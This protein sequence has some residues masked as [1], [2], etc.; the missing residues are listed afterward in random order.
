MYGSIIQLRNRSNIL[1][2]SIFNRIFRRFRYLVHKFSRCFRWRWFIWFIRFIRI[3]W[4]IWYL[5]SRWFIR[6]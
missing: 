2:C 3:K 1:N 6:F 5:R 4:F